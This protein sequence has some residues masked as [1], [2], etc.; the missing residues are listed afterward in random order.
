MQMENTLRD[1]QRRV[2]EF[3]LEIQE[4]LVKYSFILDNAYSDKPITV[5]KDM[6]GKKHQLPNSKEEGKYYAPN[7]ASI[8]VIL[9]S[10]CICRIYVVRNF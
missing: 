8:D 1:C 4:V 6:L 10:F 9:M 2:D 7:T 3:Q 5:F